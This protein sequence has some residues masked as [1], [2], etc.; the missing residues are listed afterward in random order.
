MLGVIGCKW[1][2]NHRTKRI[3]VYLPESKRYIA[4]YLQLNLGGTVSS[5]RKAQHTGVMWQ[6][7]DGKTILAIK[8]AAKSYKKWL[9]PELLV[10]LERFTKAHNLD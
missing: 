7:A 8:K 1:W 2:I 10:Q 4:N 6:T 5:V 9:P 3:R